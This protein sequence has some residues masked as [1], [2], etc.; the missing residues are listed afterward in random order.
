MTLRWIWPG[1][2]EDWV[3]LDVD[4]DQIEATSITESAVVL[5]EMSDNG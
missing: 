2:G 4:Q 5:V 3:D 1:S